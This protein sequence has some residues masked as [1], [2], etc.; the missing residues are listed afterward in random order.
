MP[1]WIHNSTDTVEPQRI[2]NE[3]I[4]YYQSNTC[5]ISLLEVYA[6]NIGNNNN[7]YYSNNYYAGTEC[8]GKVTGLDKVG[9]KFIVSIGTNT[10]LLFLIQSI[11]WLLV[12]FLI[13]PKNIETIS[14]KFSM[15][16]LP[17]LFTF[18]H[19]AES[20][21]YERLNIYYQNLDME[22][23][24][25][26]HLLGTF[27]IYLLIFIILNDLLTQREEILINYLPFAFLFVFT[28]G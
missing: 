28:L 6:K 22:L 3:F 17:L 7:I 18:Q 8:F 25:N 23:L 1:F 24:N 14:F 19:V 16:L 15:L 9:D 26:Y 2:T 12:I 21:F 10:S 11:I 27:C 20:R 5:D 4:G 13:T